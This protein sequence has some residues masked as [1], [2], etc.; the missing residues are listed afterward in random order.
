MAD[1]KTMNQDSAEVEAMS[2]QQVLKNPSTE[3]L[4]DIEL[5][6]SPEAREAA[7]VDRFSR[8]LAEVLSMPDGHAGTEPRPLA[9]QFARGLIFVAILLG[10]FQLTVIALDL[11]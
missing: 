1:K 7:R 4:I 11:F 8:P 5:D 3:K 2:A 9:A 10:L 6:D